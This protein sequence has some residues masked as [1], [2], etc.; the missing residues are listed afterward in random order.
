MHPDARLE[1]AATL[2]TPPGATQAEVALGSRIY[3]G[4]VSNGTC[5]GCHGS[6][7]K[8]SPVGADL[9]AGAWLWSDGSLE[10]LTKTLAAEWSPRGV[11]V[12]SVAPA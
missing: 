12:I 3:H 6:D 9:T 2:P 1:D 11:R 8:G 10:G 5:A 7:G 4:H